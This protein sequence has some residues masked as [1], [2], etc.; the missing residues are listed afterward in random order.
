MVTNFIM[1]M[2]VI[3]SVYL[4]WLQILLCIRVMIFS[5]YLEWLKILLRIRGII[6]SVYLEWLKILLR[7]RV[8][9][10]YFWTRALSYSSIKG[11]RRQ[12]GA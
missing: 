1:Y 7:I 2:H 4:E 8:I 10:F 9:I 3:F 12:K 6:F 5:V 11:A